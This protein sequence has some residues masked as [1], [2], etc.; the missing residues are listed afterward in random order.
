MTVINSCRPAR[1]GSPRSSSAG[2]AR[3]P[4]PGK[5]GAGGRGAC[6]DRRAEAE[7]WRSPCAGG[8]AE[9]DRDQPALV[10]LGER[11]RAL[12]QLLMILFL[13][14]FILLSDKMFRRK[15]VELR[16]DADEEKAHG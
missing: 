3:S 15:F 4:G 12:N 2:R 1:A 9:D 5:S 10:R 13:T 7:A 8:R 16:A 11:A 6:E 14:Y